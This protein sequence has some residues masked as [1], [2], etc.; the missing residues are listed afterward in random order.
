MNSW[1]SRPCRTT[2]FTSSNSSSCSG[3]RSKRRSRWGRSLTAS[4]RQHIPPTLRESNSTPP[5]QR[6]T[7]RWSALKGS[8][9]RSSLLSK[10]RHLSRYLPRPGC[11]SSQA[12]RDA[13]SQRCSVPAVVECP[14]LT[15]SPRARLSRAILPIQSGIS[16]SVR[17]LAGRSKPKGS[18]RFLRT[19]CT[20]AAS[21]PR[22]PEAA[23]P[24]T[25]AMEERR[26]TWTCQRGAGGDS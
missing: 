17:A 16:P 18:A 14:T 19:P 12:E 2:R 1:R 7:D 3:L 23:R 4:L 10:Y 21:R 22:P 6:C 11:S 26:L 13:A 25:R 9:S 24:E 5:P 15:N 8:N 20:A